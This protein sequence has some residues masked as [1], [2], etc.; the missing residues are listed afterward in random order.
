MNTQEFEELWI[1]LNEL[2]DANRFIEYIELSSAAIESAIE[3]GMYKKQSCY[4]AIAVQA[5]S[6][7]VICKFLLVYLRSIAN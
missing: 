2:Y 6:K 5:I 7:Q 1:T 3:L 4:Y